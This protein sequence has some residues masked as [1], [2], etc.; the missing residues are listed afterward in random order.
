MEFYRIV[1]V[2]RRGGGGELRENVFREIT[3]LREIY[4]FLQIFRIL[5]R[6]SFFFSNSC[7]LDV[8]RNRESALSDNILLIIRITNCQFAPCHFFFSDV[9][10]SY[11]QIERVRR[12]TLLLPIRER[13][14]RV[15]RKTIRRDFGL[16][17]NGRICVHTPRV[18]GGVL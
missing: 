13:G 18:V 7:L 9:T 15:K 16:G 5:S 11:S 4:H 12:T 3:E 8:E 17:I 6:Y 2:T 14:K 10:S 1:D